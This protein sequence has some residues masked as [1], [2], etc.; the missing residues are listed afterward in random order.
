MA[1]KT[2]VINEVT[3]EVV[4]LDPATIL[5]DINS[6][7]SLRASRIESLKNAILEAGEVYQ[8]IKVE[9]LTEDEIKANPGYEYRAVFG[10]YRIASLLAARAEGSDILM[11]VIITEPLDPVTRLRIQLSENMDRENQ[12]PI[13]KAVAMKALLDLGQ[14]RAQ[15]CSIFSSPGGRKGLKSQPLSNASLNMTISFLELPKKYQTMI[16]EGEIGV[17]DAYFLTKVLRDKGLEKVHDAVNSALAA[18]AKEQEDAEEEE[19]KFLE[20]EKKR[21]EQEAKAQE[22][23]KALESAKE[24]VAENTKALKEAADKAGQLYL[25]KTAETDKEAAK[26]AAEAHAVAE[27]EAA[28]ARKALEAAKKDLIKQSEK[29]EKAQADAKARAEKL[30]AARDAAK[31]AGAK[32]SAKATAPLNVK[33]TAAVDVKNRPNTDGIPITH[34]AIKKVVSDMSLAG[35]YPKVTAIGRALN[36]CFNGKITDG[37][38]FKNIA[39][40]TGEISETATPKKGKKG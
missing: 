7:Y 35:S 20:G 6:R 30:Q 4:M 11:P 1:A 14:T 27:K 33:K 2:A 25:A 15:V 9:P 32:S 16:H 5:T 21:A 13:D 34:A 23:L 36:D 12:S 17:A 38:L 29:A 18:R 8:P 40:I 28:E 24:A 19:I 22:A 37:Q 3:P 39:V 31:S 10:H 26:A